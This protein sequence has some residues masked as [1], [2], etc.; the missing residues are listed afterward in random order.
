M[1]KLTLLNLVLVVATAL[2]LYAEATLNTNALNSVHMPVDLSPF[3]LRE[4]G[5][6]FLPQWEMRVSVISGSL[7]PKTY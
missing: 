4:R 6:C 1:K 2:S 7:E 3:A 5:A